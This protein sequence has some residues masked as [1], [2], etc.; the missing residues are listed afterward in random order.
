MRCCVA[1]HSAAGKGSHLGGSSPTCG[2]LHL[3]ASTEEG[4]HHQRACHLFLIE[5]ALYQTL[6]M[7]QQQVW[8]LGT[9]AK[10]GAAVVGPTVSNSNALQYARQRCRASLS[11]PGRLLLSYMT[12]PEDTDTQNVRQTT[13]G[14]VPGLLLTSN[15]ASCGSS[16]VPKATC[17]SCCCSIAGCC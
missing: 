8:T 4:I 1:S 15:F 11:S 13:Y 10:A 9:R 6:H 3:L 16:A 7:I 17:V 12:S 14:L 5:E 2:F